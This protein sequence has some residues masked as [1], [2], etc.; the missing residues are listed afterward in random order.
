[1]TEHLE[2]E[3][4]VSRP[5]CTNGITK[6]HNGVNG[7][8]LENPSLQVT[9]DHKIKIASSPITRPSRG[10]ILVHIRATG[11]CGSDVHFWKRG[12]IGTLV[13][14]GDCVLGHE[15]AGIVIECG[16]GV[17]NLHVGDRVA[18][19][20][21][22]PCE[23][24]SI[25]RAGHYNLCEKVQFI[26]VYP[27]AGSM[28]R[29]ISHPAKWVYKLPPSISYVQGALL[30]P[31]SVAM[32]AISRANSPKGQPCAIFGAGPIGLLTLALAKASGASLV[33]ITDIESSRLEIA[34]M[35]VPGALTYRVDPSVKP[36]EHAAKIR[37][38]FTAQGT[39]PSDPHEALPQ[40][41]YECTGAETSVSTAVYTARRTGT[42][43]FVGVGK[44]LM[45]NLPFM[46]AQLSEITL[47]FSH[48]Y[49]DTW[50]A[51]I[52]MLEDGVL[53]DLN[54]L[55]TDRVPLERAVEAMKMS[56]DVSRGGLKVMVVDE[57]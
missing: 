57:T 21:G 52:R 6:Q 37:S 1:M 33:L 46:H 43:M 30:E 41:V 25:C 13:V 36:E 54:L 4:S 44:R 18:L 23:A 3:N 45:D 32:H 27:F 7:T 42:V 55:V 34:Q 39:M 53:G 50:P 31:L 10:Q 40:V 11:I 20:P 24:C 56:A 12:A 48:R 19:E 26:G 51:L 28:Q 17:E 49:R 15:A 16:E 29:Y 9:A 35:L 5:K 22:V 38:I 8:H 14:E 2:V 47:M